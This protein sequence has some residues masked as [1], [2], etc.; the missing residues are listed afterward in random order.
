MILPPTAENSKI[1]KFEGKL[2]LG[3]SYTHT[4]IELVEIISK[5]EKITS[6]F[7][8]KRIEF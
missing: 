4:A 7:F 2:F 3:L 1:D 6:G 5:T 8:Q